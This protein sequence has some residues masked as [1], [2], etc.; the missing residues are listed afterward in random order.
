MPYIQRVAAGRLPVLTV[1]GSDYATPDG[2][3]QRD[4]IHVVDLAA[5]H[6][7][8]LRFLEARAGGGHDVFNLGT[9]DKHTVLEVVSAFER[10]CKH[11]IPRKMGPRREGDLEAVWAD[12]SK[13]ARELGWRAQLGLDR[14]CED[15][16]RWASSNPAGYAAAPAAPSNE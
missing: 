6:V 14:M 8:A 10:A 1:H 3:A 4:Y 11:A 16:W 9:G 5:G 12:A 15:A 13:A 2:T 7:C